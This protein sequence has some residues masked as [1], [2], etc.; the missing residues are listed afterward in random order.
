MPSGLTPERRNEGM[1]ELSSIIT[2]G[3]IPTY[4]DFGKRV[5]TL[6]EKLSE[7]EFWTKPYPYGNSFG[8]LT[9]HIIGNL[10]YYIGA[11]IAR[12]GYV[13]DR[14]REFTEDDPPPKEEVLRRLD[15]VVE[16]VVKTLEAQTTDSWGADYSA[17][18]MEPAGDRFRAFLQCAAHFHH[19]IG[20]MIYLTNEHTK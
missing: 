8:H 2:N 9:L 7:Q 18:G 20:Q 5:R 16:L 15:E 19:H 17:I 3:F 10:N 12:N 1:S 6:S 13:R 4:R 14:D 11:Q